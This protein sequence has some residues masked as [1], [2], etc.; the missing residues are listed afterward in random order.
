MPTLSPILRSCLEAVEH[1]LWHYFRSSTTVDMKFAILHL[2]QAVELAFKERV[3][4]FGTSIYRRNNPKETMGYWEALGV[5]EEKRCQVPE[6]ANLELLHDER[7]A[8]QHKYSTPDPQTAAFLVEVAA[9]FLKRF[10][11]DEFGI[12]L[13][14]HVS[15][16][17]LEQILGSTP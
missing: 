1:G 14:S 2:D 13:E 6:R 4:Q 17:Y 10:M 7:N 12:S 9:G 15:L 16:E 3:R 5:I 11:H 8:I